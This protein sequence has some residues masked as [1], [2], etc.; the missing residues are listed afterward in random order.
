[1]TNKPQGGTY[2]RRRQGP[3]DETEGAPV[4]SAVE[5]VSTDQPADDPVPP[6]ARVLCCDP[7]TIALTAAASAGPGIESQLNDVRHLLDRAS[8]EGE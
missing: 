8:V 5:L 3:S 6:R 7:L 1:M 4:R 2:Q